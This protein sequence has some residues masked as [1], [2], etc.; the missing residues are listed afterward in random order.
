MSKISNILNGWQNFID[1]S[2]VSEKLAKDR[3]EY[4]SVCPKAKKGMLTAFINDSL[5]E[6]KGMYCDVCMCPLSAKI[7]SIDEKCPLE[8]WENQQPH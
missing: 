8:L 5:T 6:I 3:A 1:K 2:E 4:C 7:R